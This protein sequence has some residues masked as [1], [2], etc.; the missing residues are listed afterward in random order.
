M[1]TSRRGGGAAAGK[2]TGAVR[3]PHPA[4]EHERLVRALKSGL[5]PIVILRGEEGWYQSA[6]VRLV[7]EAAAAAGMEIC[8]HDADDPDYD[9]RRLLDDMSTG[10]L[11]GGARCVVLRSAERVVVDRA[12]KASAPVREQMLGRLAARAEGLLVLAADKLIAT[13][14]LVKAA[15]ECGGL[16]IGCRRLWDSPPPWNPDPRL[17]EPVVWLVRR[18]RERRIDL[19]PDQAAYV[20]AATGNDLAALDEQLQRIAASAR[21]GT[22][23]TTALRDVVGWESGASP[24]DIAEHMLAGRALRAVGG[25]ET[26]YRGGAAQRDGSRVLETAGI[27]VQLASAISAK[28]RETLAGAREVAGGL[29]PAA[30]TLAA[31]VK[32][33]P[34]ALAEFTQRLGL[35]PPHEWAR[36]IEELAV[37][38]RRTRTGAGADVNDFVHLALRWRLE[39]R[40]ASREALPRRASPHR[41]GSYRGSSARG[42]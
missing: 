40:V 4:D 34:Q 8:R 20:Y 27:S 16:V 41:G 6:G 32:G 19:A 5:P 9:V 11:F 13:H 36:M 25:L 28:L 21:P 39:E 7:V 14:A 2:S 42:R 15:E 24:F 22:Q 17:A 10:A 29:D 30:A 3:D 12:Q 31:G 26:L 1:A 38:E 23:Q 18:A 37:V 35:R 33:P